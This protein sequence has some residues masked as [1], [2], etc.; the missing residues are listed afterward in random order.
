MLKVIFLALIITTPVIAGAQWYNPFV[1]KTAEDCILDK[2]QNTRGDDA[3]RALREA[4]YDKYENA[5][6]IATEEANK[7]AL[8]GLSKRLKTCGITEEKWVDFR[9]GHVYFGFGGK[10]TDK[11]SVYINNI[12]RVNYSK[13]NNT[14]DFQNNNEF[15]ISGISIGFTRNKQCTTNND[16][17]EVIATCKS[18]GIGTDSGVAFRSFGL[19]DCGLVPSGVASLRYCVVSFSPIYKQWDSSLLEFLEKYGFCN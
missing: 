2:I 13:K 19:A 9:N 1:K 6:S 15:G 11:V 17:Y 8:K 5:D 7:T 12:K 3:V 14:V 18:R 16:D 10:S 4:C